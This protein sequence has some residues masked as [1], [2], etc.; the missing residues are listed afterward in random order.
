[1][2]YIVYKV[3]LGGASMFKVV[4]E[5][6]ESVGLE[7]FVYSCDSP[8]RALELFRAQIK[9]REAKKVSLILP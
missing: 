9:R 6:R 3:F 1:M 4:V 7:P 5:W 2:V 8:S